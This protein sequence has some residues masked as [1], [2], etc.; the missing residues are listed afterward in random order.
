MNNPSFAQVTAGVQGAHQR[1]V[2]N[3]VFI[4]S[5]KLLFKKKLYYK[6]INVWEPLK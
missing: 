5:F 1:K 4:N 2:F 3:Q 6:N